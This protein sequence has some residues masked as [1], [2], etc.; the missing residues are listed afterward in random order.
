MHETRLYSTAPRARPSDPAPL[1]AFPDIG[2]LHA[3]FALV[4]FYLLEHKLEY[5][6]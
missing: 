1:V 4:A 3:N 2:N 6:E 5:A